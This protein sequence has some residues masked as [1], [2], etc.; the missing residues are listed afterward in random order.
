VT[1]P[2]LLS[3]AQILDGL[4]DPALA[5]AFQTLSD[6]VTSGEFRP[7]GRPLAEMQPALAEREQ[8]RGEKP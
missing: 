7:S 8:R 2:E 5:A 4:A 6:K 1:L 3:P